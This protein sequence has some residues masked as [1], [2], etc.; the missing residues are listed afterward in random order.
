MQALAIFS[1]PIVRITDKLVSS[2]I[3][4]NE[5]FDTVLLQL[6][7]YVRCKNMKYAVVVIVV[8]RDC[9]DCSMQTFI[10]NIVHNA[11]TSDS[12]TPIYIYI[13]IYYTIAVI[14]VGSA[15]AMKITVKSKDGK[16]AT[17]RAQLNCRKQTYTLCI[18]HSL[19][20]LAHLYGR[21]CKH[22]TA[23]AKL[24]LLRSFYCT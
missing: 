23:T 18:V 6:L 1:E 9:C 8:L 5:V 16:T 21:L 24:H 12:Y 14:Q 10:I 11:I 3:P 17:V 7:Q 13:Y 19:H 22:A 20:P 15:N 2:H 4:N